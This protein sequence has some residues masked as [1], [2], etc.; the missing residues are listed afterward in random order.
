M[1]RLLPLG[2][3]VLV[4]TM[5]LSAVTELRK[6][7]ARVVEGDVLCPEQ[8]PWPTSCT[9]MGFS[10]YGYEVKNRIVEKKKNFKS[11]G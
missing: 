8:A 4:P 3:H 7:V 10:T 6:G 5:M 1:M 2:V 9:W 11:S